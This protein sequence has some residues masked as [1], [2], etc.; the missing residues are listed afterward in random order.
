MKKPAGRRR[1]QG[2]HLLHW[3]FYRIGGIP[4]VPVKLIFLNTLKVYSKMSERFL[5]NS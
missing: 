1:S 4:L 3:T 5:F 2:K